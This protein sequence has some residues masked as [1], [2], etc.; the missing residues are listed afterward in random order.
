MSRGKT[1]ASRK[2]RRI[3]LTN[4]QDTFYGR[5]KR[6]RGMKCFEKLSW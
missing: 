2:K 6:E 3:G 4:D 5:G 1:E